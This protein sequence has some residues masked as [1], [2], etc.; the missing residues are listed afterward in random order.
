MSPR[1]ACLPHQD[2]V[3]QVHVDNRTHVLSEDYSYK[4]EAYY[5]VEVNDN[6]FLESGEG[7]YYLDIYRRIVLFLMDGRGR[8]LLCG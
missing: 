5:V 3:L 6:P 2:E 1:R 7:S 8:D 4:S